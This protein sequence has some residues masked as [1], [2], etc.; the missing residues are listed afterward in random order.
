MPDYLVLWK[1]LWEATRAESDLASWRRFVMCTFDRDLE[2]VDRN[3]ACR[4]RAGGKRSAFLPQFWNVGTSASK[5]GDEKIHHP[6][7]ESSASFRLESFYK[8]TQRKISKQRLRTIEVRRHVTGAGTS[9]LNKTAV[10]E[11]N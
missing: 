8:L 7:K 11:I 9:C 10:C 1:E 5:R 2:V 4:D 6:K 3:S